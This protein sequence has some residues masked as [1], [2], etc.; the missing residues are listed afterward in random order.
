MKKAIVF[1]LITAG[2]L[3]ASSCYKN[4]Y[5]VSD[6]ALSTI[7]TISFRNDVVPIVTSGGCGC[8][9][10]GTTRQVLFMNKDTIF[11][12]TIQSRAAQFNAMAKG[13]AH[14]GEGSVFFTPSQAKIIIKWVEQGAKDD[15]VP[16]PIT[17]SI[18]YSQHIVP[19]YRTDCKGSTCH[20]GI[21][22]TLDY[23]YMVNNQP[24]LTDMM[25]S[26]G[27]KHPGGPL[28]IAPATSSTFLAWMA[29]GCK[30]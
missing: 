17:G 12:S 29:Q 24:I 28:S 9:I 14:P 3:A 5:D 8:H 1:T 2:I 15:Y 18:T 25:N 26:N 16:P 30:P 13:G 22:K 11:Y 4:Y 10:N 21:A 27:A 6:A 19:L 23:T 20:G 7:N